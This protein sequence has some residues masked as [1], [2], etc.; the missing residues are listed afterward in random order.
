[1]VDVPS[2]DDAIGEEIPLADRDRMRAWWWFAADRD[3]PETKPEFAIT[4]GRSVSD[5]WIQV[6]AQTLVRDL[7]IEPECD[8]TECSP[9]LVSLLPGE[10][11]NMVLKVRGGSGDAP[12]FRIHAH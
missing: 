11:L 9:N 4:T 3:Q 2:Q 5:L 7:W 1:M 8:W 12:T 6:H 10:R